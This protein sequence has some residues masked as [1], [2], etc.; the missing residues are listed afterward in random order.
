VVAAAGRVR[1]V[2]PARRRLIPGAS[3]GGRAGRDPVTGPGQALVRRLRHGHPQTTI[4]KARSSART[5]LPQTRALR[6]RCGR[7]ASDTAADDSDPPVNGTPTGVHQVGAEAGENGAVAVWHRSHRLRGGH[8]SASDTRNRRRVAHVAVVV[9]NHRPDKLQHVDRR[10]DHPRTGLV[11]REDGDIRRSSP[12]ILATPSDVAPAL[13]HC[14][15]ADSRVLGDTSD[16]QPPHRRSRCTCALRSR[17]PPP[18]STRCGSPGRGRVFHAPGRDPGTT[19]PRR[20]IR[21][22]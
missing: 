4:A 16:H 7:A 21:P 13:S 6:G 3:S 1:S 5:P 17:P 11:R 19:I 20:L 12:A 9:G 10:G 14:Y 2:R 18:H 22:R 15:R 8:A